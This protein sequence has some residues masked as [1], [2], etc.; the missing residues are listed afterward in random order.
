MEHKPEQPRRLSEIISNNLDEYDSFVDWIIDNY[1]GF[2]GIPVNF[3]PDD[4]KS[5]QAGMLAVGEQN[6]DWY[7]WETFQKVVK[8]GMIVKYGPVY[9]LS[10]RQVNLW[11]MEHR[12]REN[13]KI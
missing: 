9:N 13:S 8:D 12:R 3:Q 4:S 5:F 10:A 6:A 2:T 1:L 7:R 11:L